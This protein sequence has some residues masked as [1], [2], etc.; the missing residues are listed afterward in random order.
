MT[1][2]ATE[3]WT[4]NSTTAWPAQWV[5]GANNG[6]VSVANSRGRLT[7][8]QSGT[9]Q[10]VR[11]VLSGLGA[12]SAVREISGTFI[13]SAVTEQYLQI[14]G[15]EQLGSTNAYPT[16]YYLQVSPALG[17]WVL[18]G[19]YGTGQY[20]NAAAIT[21]TFTAGRVYGYKVR[22]DTFTI[23]GKLWDVTGGATEPAAFQST[24]TDTDSAFPTGVPALSQQSGAGTS[25]PYAEFGA[26]TVTDGASGAVAGSVAFSGTGSLTAAGTPSVSSTRAYTG[27]GGLDAVG[28]AKPASTVNLNGNGSLTGTGT[29]KTNGT[30]VTSSAGSLT[31]NGQATPT[32]PASS[33]GTG[34]MSLTGQPVA[35]GTLGLSG[36]ATLEATGAAA[37]AGTIALSASGSSSHTSTPKITGD[38]AWLGAGTLA[39]TSTPRATSTLS[40]TSSGSLMFATNGYASG[41]ATLAG[42]GQLTLIGATSVRSTI[43][44]DGAAA[45]TTAS[46]ILATGTLSLSSAGS[47]KVSSQAAS[48]PHTYKTAL[49]QHA[50]AAS[51]QPPRITAGITRHQWEGRV[52]DA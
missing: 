7:P 49:Q 38:T 19:G 33:T 35:V 4:A 5:A 11:R 51:L 24:W 48:A 9:Y 36:A 26:V 30:L 32:A 34:T 43:A 41:I 6:T 42:I 14:S 3:Q 10:T 31:A 23:S 52:L 20:G 39:I 2:L 22:V 44:L 15:R 1:T 13:L 46:T 50:Y 28:S 16:G 27:T 12:S 40:L 47:L 17:S 25:R 18:L 29:S 37:A 8:L 45:L 21:Q